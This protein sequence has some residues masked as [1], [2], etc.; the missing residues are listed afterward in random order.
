MD[1]IIIKALNL[2]VDLQDRIDN[3]NERLNNKLR[4]LSIFISLK[5]KQI[6]PY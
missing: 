1:Q 5:S 6:L 2:Y 3:I 4:E